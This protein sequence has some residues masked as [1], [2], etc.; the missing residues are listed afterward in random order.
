MEISK[1]PG[2]EQELSELPKPDLSH[3][4]DVI[5]SYYDKRDLAKKVLGRQA[6][7]YDE[8]KN[9]WYW[10]LETTCYKLTD[11]TNIL[12]V[13]ADV[14]SANTINSKEKTEILEALRQEARKNKPKPIKKD[15]LQFKGEIFDIKTGNQFKATPEYFAVNP[16]PW[17]LDKD[18][19]ENTPV[20]DKIFSEWVG[21]ENKQQLYEILAYCMLPD[22]PIARLFCLVG[23]GNNGKSCFLNILKKFIGIDNITST[24][25]DKLLTSRFEAGRLYK[26]LACVMGETN[27]NTMTRTSILKQLTGQDLISY[28]FK[29]KNLFTECNYAKILIA[30]N[31]LPETTDTGDGFFRRWLIIDFHN[32]FSEKIDILATIPEEEYKSLA[33]KCCT[34]LADFLKKREFT[35]DGSIEERRKRYEDK[36]NPMALFIKEF[37]NTHNPNGFI[38]TFEFDK[39]FIEWCRENNHRRFSEH[40]IGKKLKDMGFE[41]G[42]EYVTWDTEKTWDTKRQI[43]CWRGIEWIKEKEVKSKGTL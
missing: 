13:I 36:S 21:E 14:S 16:L 25:L 7:Y 38:F 43:R 22:Y 32:K 6:F 39:R 42:K 35:N 29:N 28:E 3:V 4:R 41:P 2:P 1:N 30:T 27:F 23:E 9:W 24:D 37:C 17:E 11:E 33:L 31:N 20:M 5:E 12:N 15:W 8:N 18:C 26:K 19:F 34:I 40:T 10:D